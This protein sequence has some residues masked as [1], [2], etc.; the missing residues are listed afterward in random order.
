MTTGPSLTKVSFLLLVKGGAGWDPPGTGHPGT[1]VHLSKRRH[2]PTTTYVNQDQFWAS[3]FQAFSAIRGH[4]VEPFRPQAC[5]S[6]NRL[7]CFRYGAGWDPPSAIRETEFWVEQE[8]TQFPSN[9]EPATEQIMSP[10]DH[11]THNNAPAPNWPGSNAFPWYHAA[12]FSFLVPAQQRTGHLASM[13]ILARPESANNR[14]SRPQQDQMCRDVLR[15]HQTQAIN[16][17]PIDYTTGGVGG[18][19]GTTL[20]RSKT[21][22]AALID[23][24]KRVLHR[25]PP[26]RWRVASETLYQKR[27]CH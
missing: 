23:R 4:R 22:E 1:S 24:E 18:G 17:L 5:I 10:H 14:T 8:R 27:E 16:Q 13:S 15:T 11:L 12:L 25:C 7:S 19:L 20:A 26:R 21:V 3:W 9:Q 6:P 2:F